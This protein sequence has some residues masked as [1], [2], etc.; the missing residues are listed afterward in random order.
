MKSISTL[1][2]RFDFLFSVV[3]LVQGLT[4]I[5][6]LYLT[7]K[8]GVEK[9][10]SWLLGPKDMDMYRI[11]RFSVR[12]ESRLEIHVGVAQASEKSKSVVAFTR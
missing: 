4:C 11:K 5:L 3:N 1:L 8:S 10:K 6:L 7:R 12:R 9:V 2:K